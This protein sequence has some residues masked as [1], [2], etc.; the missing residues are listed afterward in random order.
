MPRQKRFLPPDNAFH[1][2]C[3]GNNGYQVFNS[4]KDYSKYLDLVNKYKAEH[5][6]DLFHYC[7]MN[8]HVHLLIMVKEGKD[9]SN[10]MKKLN[11]AYFSYYKFNY[12]WNGHFWQDRFKSKLISKDSYLIQ[13]GKYIEMNPVRTKKTEKPEDYLWSSYNYYAKGLKNNLITR[14]LIYDSLGVTEEFRQ[15]AYQN[16]VT[17]EIFSFENQRVAQGNKKTRYNANRRYGYHLSHQN[18]PYRKT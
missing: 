1:I 10:F 7:L 5:P 3:R 13:C 16:M 17:E 2:M 11:L 15:H 8:N 9:F 14:D 6:F 12:G 4:A 18:I